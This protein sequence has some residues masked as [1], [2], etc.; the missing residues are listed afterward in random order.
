MFS[1]DGD[2]ERNRNV[3]LHLKVYKITHWKILKAGL[4]FLKQRI[5]VLQ[6]RN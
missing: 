6:R 1:G 4:R 5:K 3:K 2:I